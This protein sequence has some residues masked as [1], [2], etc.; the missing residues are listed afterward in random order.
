MVGISSCGEVQE[1][2]DEVPTLGF[3]PGL[4]SKNYNLGVPICLAR[5]C[6]RLLQHSCPFQLRIVLR[7]ILNYHID[8]SPPAALPRLPR[9][10]FSL[11]WFDRVSRPARCSVFDLAS[12]WN[13]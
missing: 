7:V 10:T 1:P 8:I 11:P 3:G 2:L 4:G 9:L 13:F 12:T 5:F 6:P